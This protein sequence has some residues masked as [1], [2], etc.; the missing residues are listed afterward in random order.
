MPDDYKKKVIEFYQK[1]KASNSLSHNLKNPTSAR[2]KKECIV[3]YKRKNSLRDND[4]LIAFFELDDDIGDLTIFLK[5]SNPEKF[6]PV[7]NFLKDITQDPRERTVELLAWLIDF[8]IDSLVNTVEVTEEKV[9]KVEDD[10]KM[11]F[12]P[13]PISDCHAKEG[14]K[15]EH[16]KETSEASDDNSEMPE[17]EEIQSVFIQDCIVEDEIDLSV[18][19][20][21]NEPKDVT[22]VLEVA[23]LY[24]NK[25]SVE[26]HKTIKK[27]NF[28]QRTGIVATLGLIMGVTYWKGI[29]PDGCMYWTGT[30]YKAVDCDAQLPNTQI[31]ALNQQKLDHFKKITLPDTMTFNSLNKVWYS[32]INNEVEFFTTKGKHPLKTDRILKPITTH[33]LGKYGNNR[34]LSLIKT[35][36]ADTTEKD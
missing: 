2:I 17:A 18:G 27:L 33:I 5:K 6:K 25:K 28:I 3:I 31:L 36:E 1:K 10:I 22:D 26:P 14:D 24:D 8:E 15:E 32:K 34:A 20:N 13:I 21:T 19:I 4:V 23:K 30:E 35:N 9:K 16:S 11:P 12:L 29:P 7:D